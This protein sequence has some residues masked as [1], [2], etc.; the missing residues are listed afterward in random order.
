MKDINILSLFGI[1]L[2]E[3]EKY[4]QVD[5]S[6]DSVTFLIRK[7][8]N[9][10]ACP[11]CGCYPTT[12]KDYRLKRYEFLSHNGIKIIIFFEHRRYVC[13]ACGKTFFETNPFIK[14]HNY[15]INPQKIIQVINYLKDGLP[16][17]L[18]SKYSFISVS[19]VNLIL[20][21]VV[22]VKRR[23]MPNIL[24]IDEFCS[25][26]S[27][28]E[29]K[30]AC[31]LIDYQRGCVVDVLPSRRSDWLCQYLTNIGYY[32][33]KNIQYIVMDMYRPYM[34]S[35]KK[36]NKNIEFIIDPF[37]YISYVTDAIDKVRLRIM[38]KFLIDDPEYKLLKRYR[39]LLLTKYEPDSYRKLK[40]IQIWGDKRMYNSDILYA[41]LS[42]DKDMEEAYFLGHQFLKELDYMNYAK[43]HEFLAN[44][45]ARYKMSNLKEFR[46]VGETFENWRHEIEN[47]YL[48][49]DNGKRVTNAKIE[50]RN[51][52]IK[53]LKKVCYGLT[54]F[55]HLRKRV[56]LIFEKDPMK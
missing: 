3:L 32:E 19:S 5:G 16:A 55:D 8:K 33:L 28:I 17:T 43:F 21:K 2:S 40:R 49:I 31:L 46:K 13:K 56:F 44:T 11:N 14:N 52:K 15:K 50:G 47:S 7:T 45:I 22:R 48:L 35:F 34:D 30:Y 38:K 39:K 27:A 41:I 29:S 26:N 6:D 24:S 36:F 18:I 23:G 1:E 4:D 9:L 37:H 10:L 53:T 51:N 25:F 54:N 42:V 12:V 20:D